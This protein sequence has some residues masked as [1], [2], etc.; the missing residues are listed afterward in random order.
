MVASGPAADLQQRRPPAPCRGLARRRPRRTVRPS[1]ELERDPRRASARRPSVTCVAQLGG[2]AATAASAASVAG[3]PGPGGAPVSGTT[4]GGA[5]RD[6]SNSTPVASITDE[7][8][9]RRADHGDRH[10]LDD[11]DHERVAASRGSPRPRRP[12]AARATRPARR[13]DVHPGQRRAGRRPPA[14]SPHLL[15]GERCGAVDLDRRTPSSGRPSSTPATA[16]AT[17]SATASARGRSSRRRTAARAAARRAGSGATGAAARR[18]RS[19]RRARPG[20]GPGRRCRSGS[21]AGRVAAGRRVRRPPPAGA[22]RAARR[23]SRARPSRRR[24]RP[25]SPPRRRAGPARP[26]PA[27]PPHDG[28]KNTRPAGSGTAS[29]TIAPSRPG[30]GSSPGAE[31]LHHDA[32]SASASAARSPPRSRGCGRGTAGSH[33]AAG[34]PRPPRG[35]AQRAVDRGRVVGVLV[36]DPDPAD[37]ALELEAPAHAG[38]RASASISSGGRQP[39]LQPGQQGGGAV[40]R[41]VPPGHRDP[42]LAERVPVEHGQ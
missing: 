29:A 33:H 17:S 38:E 36:V 4:P 3:S 25:W 19:D 22:G 5:R 20:A 30:T 28:S 31:D 10:P 34:R 1:V 12:G 2:S 15:G 26:A 9:R 21:P 18:R 27:R 32:S 7:P 35:S 11:G 42:H 23:A 24:R 14:A 13:V 16:T 6:R 41:H 39:E 40:E 37:D 8:G